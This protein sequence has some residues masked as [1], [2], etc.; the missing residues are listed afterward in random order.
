MNNIRKGSKQIEPREAEIYKVSKPKPGKLMPIEVNSK[1]VTI[2]G[3]NLMRY[4]Y[5]I[6]SSIPRK[7]T[8]A[9]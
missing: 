4:Y 2:L 8:C 5:I 3:N 1:E 9:A 6:G 7:D